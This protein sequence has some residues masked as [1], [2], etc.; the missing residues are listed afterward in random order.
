[1][2]LH[3]FNN[4]LLQ[5]IYESMVEI[6]VDETPGLVDQAIEAKVDVL[7]IVDALTKGIDVVGEKFENLEC[8]LPEL[9]ISAKAMEKCMATVRPLLEKLNLAGGSPGTIVVATLQGDI[10]DIGRNIAIV[11]LKASGFT[12]YDLGHDVKPDVI[13][14]KARELNADVIGL[15]SLLTTSLPFSRDM[16]NLLK[17]QNLRDKF[18]VVMGGGAV[19]PDYVERIGADG[20][21]GDAPNGVKMIRHLLSGE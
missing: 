12:V 16:M 13:I 9:M 18:L 21:C 20:F 10:H 19:T 17:E 4:A 14:Q 3:K 5:Q 15:S 1:M 8:F 7:E 11:M 2:E 6:N